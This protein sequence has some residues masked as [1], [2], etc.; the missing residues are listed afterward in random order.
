MKY[1]KPDVRATSNSEVLFEALHIVS[2]VCFGS[3][4]AKYGFQNLGVFLS[5]K[6]Y[7][8]IQIRYVRKINS[9]NFIATSSL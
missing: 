5:S 6:F 2:N 8:A 9:K 1:S 3:F 7:I 4:V